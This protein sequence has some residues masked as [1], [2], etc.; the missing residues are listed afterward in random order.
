M[1]QVKIS[2]NASGTGVFEI[3]A[4]NSNTN[5]TL[6][7][8]QATTTLVGTDATQTLTN[9]TLTTPNIDS[10]QFATVSGTAPIYGCR[11]WVMFDGT[12]NVTNTGA[13]TNG[14]AVY[15]KASGNVTSVVKNATGDFTIT[16]TTA[17]PDINYSAVASGGQ[18]SNATCYI[19]TAAGTPTTTTCRVLGWNYLGNAVDFAYVSVAIFR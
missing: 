18:A 3:A 13:S 4:P 5:Y 14:A 2:G 10:A 15:L 19:G 12:R 17:M 8:P 16:F 7:L 11:A 6:T 9:K 1:S